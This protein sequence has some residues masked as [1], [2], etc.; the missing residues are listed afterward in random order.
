M[1]VDCLFVHINFSAASQL[2]RPNAKMNPIKFLSPRRSV[3]QHKDH[4][5]GLTAIILI[6]AIYIYV[7]TYFKL[8]RVFFLYEFL[9]PNESKLCLL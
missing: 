8:V 2:H 6:K 3:C 7:P 9:K 5:K 4:V 1:A